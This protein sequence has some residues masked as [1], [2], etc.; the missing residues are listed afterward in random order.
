MKLET[1]DSI[2]LVITVGLVVLIW[3][4]QLVHY[5]SFAYYQENDFAKAMNFHQSRITLI[6]L[7]LM[8]IEIAALSYLSWKVTDLFYLSMLAMVILIWVSTFFIQVPLH[9][10]L[11]AG[12]DVTLITKLVST[13]WIRTCLWTLKLGTLIMVATQSHSK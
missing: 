12:K 1:V 9:Q 7:P 10:K 11:L 6:V 2:H 5:P 3:I 13:N 8:M 4:I